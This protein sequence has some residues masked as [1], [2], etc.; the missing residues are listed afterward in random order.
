MHIYKILQ[1]NMG[2]RWENFALNLLD[3]ISCYLNQ[4]KILVQWITGSHYQNNRDFFSTKTGKTGILITIVK[5]TTLKTLKTT[6]NIS[7]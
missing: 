5:M 2:K 3:K 1:G 6:G 7:I 4:N